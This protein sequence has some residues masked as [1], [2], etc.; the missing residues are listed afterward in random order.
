MAM[1]NN[2]MVYIYI[3]GIWANRQNGTEIHLFHVAW[4]SPNG[5]HGGKWSPLNAHGFYW[6]R[7]PW[8][9]GTRP[10]FYIQ[11][12]TENGP[13]EIVDLPIYPLKMVDLSIVFCM[14]SR[15]G[16]GEFYGILARYCKVTLSI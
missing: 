3:H 1:L 11:K 7:T 13:V 4:I 16:N 8:Y 6:R 10:G 5:I 9:C 14:F 2:Q 15:P 12:A